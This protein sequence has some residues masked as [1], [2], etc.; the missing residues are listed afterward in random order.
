MQ[1]QIRGHKA[2]STWT[3]YSRTKGEDASAPNLLEIMLPI[4]LFEATPAL[5][6]SAVLILVCESDLLA[7][8]NIAAI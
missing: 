5:Q 3:D 2:N 4:A 1:P 6:A 8:T 7:V